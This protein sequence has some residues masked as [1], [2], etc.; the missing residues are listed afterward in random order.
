MTEFIMTTE[1]QHLKN[2]HHFGNLALE[3]AYCLVENSPLIV[4][5]CIFDDIS[6]QTKEDVYA[7]LLHKHVN[8]VGN[9]IFCDVDTDKI[10]IKND[11]FAFFPLYFY[12]NDGV[13]YVS[14]NAWNILR[15]CPD[16]SID[17]KI[18]YLH[19][20]MF[21]TFDTSRTF[22]KKI[23]TAAPGTLTCLDLATCTCTK[24]ELADDIATQEHL[25]LGMDEMALL[26]DS[27]MG[28]TY[29]QLKKKLGN[30]PVLFG[31]SGGLDS[32]LVPHYARQAGIEIEGFTIGEEFEIPRFASI[33]FR[34][35]EE[36]SALYQF[37]N[38]RIHYQATNWLDRLL[39]DIRNAPFL[40]AEFFKNP[41]DKMPRRHA[42]NIC[43]QPAQA[44]GTVAFTPA[45]YES[46]SLEDFC[47]RM[48]ASF[49]RKTLQQL[50]PRFPSIA[51]QHLHE[52]LSQY[53]ESDVLTC[54]KKVT[55]MIISKH[56]TTCGGFES[57]SRTLFTI[58][59]YYPYAYQLTREYGTQALFASR[60]MLKNLM[61]LK[62]KHFEKL[63]D[64]KGEFINKDTVD[65]AE[66]IS[67]VLKL[68]GTGLNYGQWGYTGEYHDFAHTVLALP[69]SL[70]DELLPGVTAKVLDSL[71]PFQMGTFL[72]VRLLLH[73]VEYGNY[74]LLDNEAFTMAN[75][76]E[77]FGLPQYCTGQ[78]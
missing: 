29:R 60:T 37:V 55:R 36:L 52:F 50:M 43:G 15:H 51:S 68:C 17:R 19:F 13:V 78:A 40:T 26:L 4:E 69:S 77:T 74:H 14:N 2:S 41:F 44:V 56:V 23:H 34:N 20:E 66:E 76:F 9:I 6:V 30:E 47:H 32:R 3:G 22:F 61:S 65:G 64:Q 21:N 35:A 49:Q 48:C 24:R 73:I 57:C 46:A 28:K 38:H 1:G 72:K 70:W 75:R 63:S 27:A 45:M 58:P 31:N 11:D 18:F 59:Q 54:I 8:G 12:C 53:P 16:K 67:T 10:Y 5:G 42:V 25:N 39:L 33:T 7:K 71:P 62:M